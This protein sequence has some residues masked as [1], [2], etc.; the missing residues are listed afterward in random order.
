[1]TRF[2]KLT[3]MLPLAMV[4]AVPACEFG[5]DGSGGGFTTSAGDATG[6]GS[7]TASGSTTGAGAGGPGQPGWTVIPMLDDESDPKNIVYHSGNTLVTGIHFAS[8]DDGYVVSAG[9]NQTFS[10]GGA[11]FRAKQKEV[12]EVLFSGN[13]TA[14]CALGTTDFIGIEPTPGGYMAKAFACDLVSSKDGGATF[15][16]ERAGAGNAFGLEDTLAL[17][18]LKSGALM[19]RETGVI[20]RTSSSPGPTAVWTDTWAPGAVPPIPNPVPADQCQSG[21]ESQGVP[22]I[23][24]AAYVSPNGQLIAYTSS[25][26]HDPQICISNDGGESFY[27][28]VLAGVAEDVLFAPPT[29][30]VF[31][32]PM[33]GITFYANSLYAGLGY[34]FHTTDGGESWSKVELPVDVANKRIELQRAFFAPDGDHGWLVGFDYDSSVALLLKTSDGGASWQMS[35]GDLAAKV[36]ESGGGKLSTGFALDANHIWVGG[37]DGIFAANAAGGE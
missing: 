8:I 19:V 12:T 6:N 35:G 24:Q 2:P 31:T 28:K 9:A 18:Y 10:Y 32:T 25:P 26:D 11:V 3:T 23:D 13:Q 1:M 14:T 20:S 16:V 27:P 33:N 7:T 30:V 34:V 36:A 17:R 37:D 29:G 15:G 21:P 5:D 22:S 4:F